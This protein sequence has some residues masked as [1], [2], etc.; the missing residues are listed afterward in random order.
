MEDH[1]VDIFGKSSSEGEIRIKMENLTS[2]IQFAEEMKGESQREA[3]GN[4]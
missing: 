3:T 4:P 1:L 2:M